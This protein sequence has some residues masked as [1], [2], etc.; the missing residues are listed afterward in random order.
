MKE[1]TKKLWPKQ[2]EK[3]SATFATKEVN[4]WQLNFLYS[5]S[6]FINGMNVRAL[7]PKK[8]NHKQLI[9]GQSYPTCF[10]SFTRLFEALD[11]GSLCESGCSL[12]KLKLK[13]AYDK[14]NWTKTQSG[15]FQFKQLLFRKCRAVKSQTAAKGPDFAPHLAAFGT[16]ETK[17]D[18]NC[19]FRNHY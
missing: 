1:L 11:F 4:R 2:I 7:L 6:L 12:F 5:H 16:K 15:K 13:L 8:C 19:L 14:Q 3:F 17:W 10:T 9:G 18:T